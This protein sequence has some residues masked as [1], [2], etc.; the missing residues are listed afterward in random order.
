MPIC[1]V[2]DSLFWAVIGVMF[3]IS[4]YIVYRY[5][6]QQYREEN[7]EF[8]S[9]SKRPRRLEDGVF[10]FFLSADIKSFNCSVNEFIQS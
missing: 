1:T 3:G 4:F 2:I 5:F 6:T 9:A 10:F 7:E 8:K